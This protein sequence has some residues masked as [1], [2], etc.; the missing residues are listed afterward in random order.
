MKRVV[1]AA[2]L[3]AG[4]VGAPVGRSAP[5]EGT[6]KIYL[7]REA[8]VVG[9]RIDLGAVGVV[10]GDEA[11]A[12]RALPVAVG[13]FSAAGQQMVIDRATILAMLAS[14]GIDTRAVAISGA[15]SVT[16]RR[17]EDVIAPERFIAAARAFVEEQL[18]DPSVSGMTVI[19]RPKPWVIE[20]PAADVRLAPKAHPYSIPSR[21]RV[22]VEVVVDGEAQ[23]GCEVAFCL[24]YKHQRIVATADIAEGDPITTAN[25]KVE[26]VET[27]Y[28]PHAET[29]APY[30]MVARRAIRKNSLIRDGMVGPEVPPAVI[31]RRQVVLV[32]LETPL[33]LVSSFGEAMED[34]GTGDLIRV[35]VNSGRDAKIIVTQIQNDGTVS[36]AK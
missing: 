19:S 10:R 36:P 1:V 4:L 13:R 32:K 31:K 29:P 27:S 14:A 17:D 23:T 21:P 9:E 22:W 26:T 20:N 8:V 15:E 33:L 30:G 2:A 7:P 12:A 18:K 24:R 5:S 25:V 11:A 28:A 16:V 34:G 3:L 35:R 6:L